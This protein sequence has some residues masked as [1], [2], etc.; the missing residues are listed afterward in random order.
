[1]EMNFSPRL[2]PN[3][4]YGVVTINGKPVLQN[5]GTL[6][7]GENTFSFMT[8]VST[9][10]AKNSF[11]LIKNL[12][13]R[14]AS[15]IKSCQAKPVTNMTSAADQTHGG[16]FYVTNHFPYFLDITVGNFTP[17]PYCIYPFTSQYVAVSTAYQN[18]DVLGTHT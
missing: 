5:T 14:Y 1:M 10:K 17:T 6:Q 4:G 15:T 9:S 12:D 8:S 7:S 18:I 3:G 13:A 16:Y 2:A 11:L